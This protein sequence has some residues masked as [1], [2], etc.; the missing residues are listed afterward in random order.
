MV[1]AWKLTVWSFVRF[2]WFF[3]ARYVRNADDRACLLGW[4]L[5]H[6]WQINHICKRVE[7]ALS[8]DDFVVLFRIGYCVISYVYVARYWKIRREKL[9]RIEKI[10]GHGTLISIHLSTLSNTLYVRT[11]SMSHYNGVIIFNSYEIKYI[12]L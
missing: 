12:F 5:Y 2:V 6:I 7:I 11:P 3:C 1:T 8:N 9:Q 4:I 10:S